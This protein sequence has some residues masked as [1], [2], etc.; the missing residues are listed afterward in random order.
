MSGGSFDRVDIR[1]LD[2][3]ARWV[4]PTL[5]VQTGANDC[6][7]ALPLHVGLNEGFD[8]R[9]SSS[10]LPTWP[11][12]SG[13]NDIWFS[14]TATCS[15]NVRIETCGLATFDTVLEALSGPCANLSSVACNDDACTL[16]S[17]VTFPVSLGERYLVRVGGFQGQSG[18]VSLL[19]TESTSGNGT[20]FG[21]GSNCGNLSLNATGT[22]DIGGAVQY[23]MSGVEGIPFLMLGL[24]QINYPLCP[25]GC[26]LRVLPELG[27]FATSSLQS[28]VPCDP[29]L[30]GGAFFIQGIDLGGSLGCNAGAPAQL[31]ATHL[32]RT[33][34]G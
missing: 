15:G 27:S 28:P 20:F 12:G 14:Y 16:Q 33:T 6:C 3:N 31:T 2:Q 1:A 32:I 5:F 9:G 25:A 22:P 24:T 4:I 29:L 17:M 7:D 8:T 30:I 26:T 13:A 21:I 34:I 23:T 19:V 18:S 11:C 10:S